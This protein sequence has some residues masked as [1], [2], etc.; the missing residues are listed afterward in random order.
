MPS[1]SD[2]SA[3]SSDS[4]KGGKMK[5][6]LWCNAGRSRTLREKEKNY[7]RGTT[8]RLKPIA[9]IPGT[10]TINILNSLKADIPFIQMFEMER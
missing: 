6:F 5:A 2:E 9:H 1:N 3:D 8:F 4:G 7:K 10:C